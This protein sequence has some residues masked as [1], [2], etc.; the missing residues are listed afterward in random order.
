MVILFLP[1]VNFFVFFHG[2]MVLIF[3]F[4]HLSNSFVVLMFL[5]IK[6]FSNVMIFFIPNVAL[7]VKFMILVFQVFMFFM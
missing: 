7:F 5:M 1:H 6:V 3:P 2:V 4:V